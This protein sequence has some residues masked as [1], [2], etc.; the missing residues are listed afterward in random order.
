[1]GRVTD[2]IERLSGRKPRTLET[3]LA[4]NRALFAA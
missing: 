4:A 3:W 1:M 2:A